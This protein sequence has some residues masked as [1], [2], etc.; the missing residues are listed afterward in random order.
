MKDGKGAEVITP[1]V[2]RDTNLE[3]YS[4]IDLIHKCYILFSSCAWGKSS[5][6]WCCGLILE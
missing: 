2:I 1:Q 5:D 3:I 4:K 6:V